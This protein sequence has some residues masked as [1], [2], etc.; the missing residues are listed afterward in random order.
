MDYVKKEVHVESFNQHR[1]PC[2]LQLFHRKYETVNGIDKA[3]ILQLKYTP[4]Q[5][6]QIL[7]GHSRL[8]TFLHRI[9]VTED[10]LCSCNLSPE[11]IEHYLFDCP[12]FQTHRTPFKNHCIRWLKTS[13][14]SLHTWTPSTP[15][16]KILTTSKRLNF[17]LNRHMNTYD[18]PLPVAWL[19]WYLAGLSYFELRCVSRCD[20]AA[21]SSVLQY[22]ADLDLVQN[23]CHQSL[24]CHSD[25]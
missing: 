18:I 6:I 19:E 21:L 25:E 7:S 23:S 10:D 11:T 4:H 14:K 13:I 22:L 12:I 15:W 9:G 5:L 16:K 3:K 8:R 1:I 24:S 20:D 17:D 2:F